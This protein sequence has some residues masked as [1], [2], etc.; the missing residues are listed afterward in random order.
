[1]AAFR[2]VRR[3]LKRGG[4]LTMVVWRKKDENPFLCEIEQR[5]LEL[6]PVPSQS[7]EPTCGPGPFSMASPD[8]VS[9]QLKAAGF[10]R[11]AFERFDTDITIGK[12]V[13]EAVE[14]AMALGPAGEVLRLAG[15]DG[16]RKRGQVIAAVREV[17]APKVTDR[18]V[19]AGSSSWLISARAADA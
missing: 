16:V 7:N 11:I 17:L 18:G 10:D 4:T 19:V 9:A 15:E 5:V 8:V 1:V 2:N 13:D 14:F 12:D 6:V 3:A